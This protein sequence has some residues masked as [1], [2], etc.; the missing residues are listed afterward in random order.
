MTSELEKLKDSIHALDL[1]IVKLE[2]NIKIGVAVLGLVQ[3]LL[4]AAQLIPHLK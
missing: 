3:F 1:R 2:Q 4:Q